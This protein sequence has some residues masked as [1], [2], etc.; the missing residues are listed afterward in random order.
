MPKPLWVP[1]VASCRTVLLFLSVNKLGWRARAKSD[2]DSL[3]AIRSRSIAGMQ[4]KPCPMPQPA[5][6]PPASITRPSRYSVGH[7]QART[8]SGVQRQK[9]GKTRKD[10]Q[11]QPYCPAKPW[12]RGAGTCRCPASATWIRPTACPIDAAASSATIDIFCWFQ[13]CR[14]RAR[15]P[16]GVRNSPISARGRTSPGQGERVERVHVLASVNLQIAVQAILTK[17]PVVHL[18]VLPALQFGRH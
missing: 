17:V 7:L 12:Q 8:G 2:A 6:L 3:Q 14:A 10:C 16:P 11:L 18:Q 5:L 15:K 4:E 1:K 9:L 13:R